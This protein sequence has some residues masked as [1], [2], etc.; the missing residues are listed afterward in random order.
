M[1]PVIAIVGAPNSGKSSIFNLVASQALALVN[2]T[3]STTR[4]RNYVVITR[5]KYPFLLVDTGG[6]LPKTT[7]YQEEIEKQTREAIDESDQIWFVV[8]GSQGCTTFDEIILKQLRKA[9]KPIILIINKIKNDNLSHILDEFTHLGIKSMIPISHLSQR[10][11]QPLLSLSE[12]FLESKSANIEVYQPT[13]ILKLAVIGRPNAGKST[14]VNAVIDKKRLIESDKPGTT[15]NAIYI[16][17]RYKKHEFTLIDTAG[18]RRF[19]H[20]QELVEKISVTQALQTM[21]LADI[22]LLMIDANEGIVEQDLK[23][24][25]EIVQS[26]KPFIICINKI[27]C[28]NSTALNKLKNEIL[29]KIHFFKEPIICFLSA[30]KKQGIESVVSK[31]LHLYH[32]V[33]R[34][35]ATPKLNQLLEKFTIAHPAPVI[36]GKRIKLRY[37]HLGTHKPLTLICHGSHVHLLPQTYIRYLVTSFRKALQ[38]KGIP[39]DL[40]FR[41]KK[42][43][44]RKSS[45]VSK[46]N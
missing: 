37:I 33:S 5:L 6:F 29:I 41:E 8:D 2:E 34:P 14:F 20:F 26:Y 35:I 32:Q 36:H 10:S 46:R 40:Q 12:T 31:A 15:T 22:I 4:D 17:A 11:I 38:L 30:K 18:I 39:I 45:H 24:I 28:L 7:L 13:E 3:A 16:P 9:N 27:D 43:S 23:L 1:L 21:Y 25:N 19:K 44:G 42:I